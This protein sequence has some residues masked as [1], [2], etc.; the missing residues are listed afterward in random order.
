MD[1]RRGLRPRN[2]PSRPRFLSVVM[3]AAQLGAVLPLAD[4]RIAG[5]CRSL[6]EHKA[7]K[8]KGAAR[9]HKK[10]PQGAGAASAGDLMLSRA[11]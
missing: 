8:R 3:K 6:A 4:R 11:L 9:H 7:V 10:Q 2:I 1:L 5:F